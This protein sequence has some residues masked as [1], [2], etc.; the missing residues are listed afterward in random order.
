LLCSQEAGPGN[1]ISGGLAVAILSA[2][3]DEHRQLVESIPD[4]TKEDI[5]RRL[6]WIISLLVD[7][8]LPSRGHLLRVNE[9]LLSDPYK[10]GPPNV[11]GNLSGQMG[12]LSTR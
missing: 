7:F 2:C 12:T 11:D 4:L 8:K 1:D 6:Q 10:E 5:R 9:V 3:F